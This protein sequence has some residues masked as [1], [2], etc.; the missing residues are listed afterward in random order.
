M[1]KKFFGCYYYYGICDSGYL[2]LPCL[3]TGIY[4]DTNHGLRVMAKRLEAR[5]HP[6]RY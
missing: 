4:D 6:E 1:L 3:V 5:F 2:L